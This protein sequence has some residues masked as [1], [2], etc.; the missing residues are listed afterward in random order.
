MPRRHLILAA[1]TASVVL[2]GCGTFTDNDV[3]AS[4]DDVELTES[5]LRSFAEEA[6][7][8]PADAVDTLTTELARDLISRF[9]ITELLAADLDALGAVPP[10]V[11]TEGMLPLEATDA[12]QTA[13]FAVWQTIPPDQL[14]DEAVSSSYTGRAERAES[15]CLAQINVAN[16]SDA[17]AVRAELDNGADFMGVA[18]ALTAFPASAGSGYLGCASASEVEQAFGAEYVEQLGAVDVGEPADAVETQFGFS[19]GRVMP[20]DE[21]P[22]NGIVNARVQTFDDRYDIVIDPR[23]GEWDPSGS[24][25]PVG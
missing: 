4:V 18:E 7:G 14:V 23:Y 19:I 15:Y 6:T 21:L 20:F 11:D 12:R 1:A 16:A 13:L 22:P 5:E 9:V 3:V 24:I 17:E 8:L 25:V 2:S 10:E